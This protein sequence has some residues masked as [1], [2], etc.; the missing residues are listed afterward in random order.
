MRLTLLVIPQIL[1][2]RMICSIPNAIITIPVNC[3]NPSM[4]YYFV[5]VSDHKAN[6]NQSPCYE[7]DNG[8]DVICRI[9]IIGAI[10]DDHL[11]KRIKVA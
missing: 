2:K 1:K 9:Q 7:D 10:H 5:L 8:L 4:I 3:I 11:D 6:E